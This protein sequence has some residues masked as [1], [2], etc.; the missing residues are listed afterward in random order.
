MA[1]KAAA[2]RKPPVAIAP[3]APIGPPPVPPKAEA[4]GAIEARARAARPTFRRG[5]MVF[6]DRDW[7][8]LDPQIG[9][10]AQLAILAEPVLTV[11]VKGL[12]GEWRSLTA[13]DRAAIVA[14]GTIEIGR[15]QA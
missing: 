1:R 6:N 3:I 8:D 13:G 2:S 14:V 11:Q 10:E 12:D 9:D 4:S 15:V 7:T 5:G